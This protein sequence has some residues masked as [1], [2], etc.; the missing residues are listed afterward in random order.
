MRKLSVRPQLY[1]N[2]RERRA[3]GELRGTTAKGFM[4]GFGKG[5]WV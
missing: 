4:K 1:A 2:M 5:K 3:K